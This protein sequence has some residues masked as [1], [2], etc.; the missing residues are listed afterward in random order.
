[1]LKYKV[2][3]SP[4]V[5]KK[6]EMVW[7]E[8]YLAPDLS[9][10]TGVTSQDYHLE[11][12]DTIEA[13][14]SINDRSGILNLETENVEREGYV[15]LHGMSYDVFNDTFFDYQYA[16]NGTVIDYKYVKINTQ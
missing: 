4:D 7:R 11:K 13:A 10:V 15:V 12:Y 9:F 3:L 1:M 14:N 2:R 6:E 16:N 5:M 8:K